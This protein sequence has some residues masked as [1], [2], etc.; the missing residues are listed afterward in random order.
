MISIITPSYNAE[1][2][3]GKCIENVAQQ[4]FPGLEHIIMDAGSTDKTVRIIAEAAAKYPHI[5]WISE[6][7]KGQSD[8]MNKGI[9][10]AANP[11]IGFLNVDDFYETGALAFACNFFTN[12]PAGTFLVGN[13]NV[14]KE[15]G[16]LYMVN[17]PY[18]VD[19]VPYMLDYTFPYNPSA[20][21]YHKQLHQMAGL[22][23][24]AD[25]LTMDVDF[26]FRLLYKANI[27]Y[28]NQTLGNYVMVASSKT[29]QEISAGR[30]VENLK[31][32]FAR[33]L[34]GFPLSVR[35]N[36]WFQSSL[37]S[38]RGWI[39]YYLRHPTKLFGK[40]LGKSSSH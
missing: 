9:A 37:G 27:V 1:R 30:N 36:Y 4:A 21:F 40:L 5:R 6:K 38:N 11:V 18:P 39:M 35:L 14:L 13:C 25:H 19:A 15:D 22:Y 8:A 2:F 31:I 7:D 17:K 32:I 20:Y 3:I 28:V 12:A 34:P 23:Q 16:S 10:L 33:H 26:I 29:M 24:T